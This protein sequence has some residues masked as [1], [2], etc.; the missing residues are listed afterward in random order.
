MLFS[1]DR[2]QYSSKLNQYY[3]FEFMEV[4]NI[5][6][7]V[8]GK[9][10]LP[11]KEFWSTLFG[12]IDKIEQSKVD[13]LLKLKINVVKVFI[14]YQ[15]ERNLYIKIELNPFLNKNIGHVFTFE[16]LQIWFRNLNNIDGDSQSKGLGAARKNNFDQYVNSL[17]SSLYNISDFQDDNGLDL[18]KQ[19]LNGD[20]TK[21]FDLD[22]FQYISSTSEF[23]I[24]EFLKREN[25]YINNIQAHPMRYCWSGKPNDNK[26]K[27]ISLWNL[28]SFLNGRLLLV[29]YSDDIYEK[30][31]VIEILD[32]DVNNGILAENKYC[33]SRNEFLGWLHDMNH[34]SNQSK[35]YLSDFKCV[36]YDREFF[37]NFNDN[38]KRYGSEFIV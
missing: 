36:H 32:L 8:R 29:N 7:L 18:T 16:Q 14:F 2:I 31:S 4:G 15:P 37:K 25:P 19:L 11:Q 3:I 20:T 13:F 9:A 22:L 24:Y 35:D 33:M 6:N 17:L 10:L 34:Y 26:Q 30:I 5:F 28:R 12:M 21:G 38:K 27:Y 1:I 23:I